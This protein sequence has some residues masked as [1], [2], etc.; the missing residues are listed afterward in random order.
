MAFR[1]G[2]SNLGKK[3]FWTSVGRLTSGAKRHLSFGFSNQ[4][5]V[6]LYHRFALG[7]IYN[8]FTRVTG[9]KPSKQ[10]YKIGQAFN[11]YVLSVDPVLDNPNYGP[12]KQGKISLQE[13]KRIPVSRQKAS[14]FVVRLKKTNLPKEQKRAIIN[15]FSSF[16]KRA[17]KGVSRTFSN[18]FADYEEVLSGVKA[19]AGDMYGTWV[20]IVGYAQGLSKTEVTNLRESFSNM[21]TGLQFVDDAFDC[22]QDFD[23]QQNLLISLSK[24]H[25]KEFEFLKRASSNPHRISFAWI[26]KNLPKTSAELNFE[27]NRFSLQIPAKHDSLKRF[28]RD[29]FYGW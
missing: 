22:L 21:S 29:A 9:V 23:K 18:P 13:L 24:K 4:K 12:R 27:F 17:T 1:I 2:V 20:E 25:E 28:M 19:T 16:R 14:E 7:S 11:G 5:E 26:R 15:A 8:Q 3:A 6:K 10:A